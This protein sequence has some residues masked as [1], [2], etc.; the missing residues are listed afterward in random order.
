MPCRVKGNLYAIKIG[1]LVIGN[2][3]NLYVRANTRLEDGYRKMMA[4]IMLHSFARMVSMTMHN[5]RFRYRA[6][7]VYIKP[8]RNA[9]YPFGTKPE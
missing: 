6:P 2:P 5:Q 9:I 8:A 7:G 4:E 1:R 3:L